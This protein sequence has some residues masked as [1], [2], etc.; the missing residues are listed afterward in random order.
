[1]EHCIIIIQ[2]QDSVAGYRQA[3][4]YLCPSRRHESPVKPPETAFL[5]QEEQ[6][7][8]VPVLLPRLGLAANSIPAEGALKLVKKHKLFCLWNGKIR[9]KVKNVKNIICF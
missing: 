6:P 1:M 8:P 5:S 3:Q 7:A 4:M 9:W 2:L